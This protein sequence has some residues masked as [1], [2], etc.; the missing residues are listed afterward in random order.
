MSHH[1]DRPIA[2][3]NSYESFQ[4]R[5]LRGELGPCALDSSY[6]RLYRVSGHDPRHFIA[7]PDLDPGDRAQP[8][9]LIVAVG[10]LE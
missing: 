3:N 9:P 6:R 5:R 2:T 7:D 8:V 10:E 1:L 4:L